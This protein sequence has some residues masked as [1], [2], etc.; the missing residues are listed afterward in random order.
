MVSHLST[1]SFIAVLSTS[2]SRDVPADFLYDKAAVLGYAIKEADVSFA[3]QYLKSMI[4][5]ILTATGVKVLL[6]QGQMTFQLNS[7]LSGFRSR[8]EDNSSEWSFR[9]FY[10][11]LPIECRESEETPWPISS[12]SL[13]NS[14]AFIIW[15]LRRLYQR[16]ACFIFPR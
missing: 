4:Y 9:S 14:N 10:S 11:V 13:F 1:F 3:S 15:R 7:G 8:S 16:H 5:T 6:F 2:V 12:S